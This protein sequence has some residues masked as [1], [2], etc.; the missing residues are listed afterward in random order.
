MPSWL[1]RKEWFPYNNFILIKLFFY[2]VPMVDVHYVIHLLTQC[3]V[4]FR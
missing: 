4:S 2:S 3:E 1:M